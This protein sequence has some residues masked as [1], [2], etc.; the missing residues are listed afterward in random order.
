MIALRKCVKGIAAVK[1]PTASSDRD[2]FRNQ[3]FMT[4]KNSQEVLRKISRLQQRVKRQFHPIVIHRLLINLF[5]LMN[6][7]SH[8]WRHQIAGRSGRQIFRLPRSFHRN[9]Q[10]LNVEAQDLLV[11]A[12]SAPRC[13]TI[14]LH[15]PRL[16]RAAWER[17]LV[18]VVLVL[19]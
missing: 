9:A 18:T 16:A 6:R 17:I 11:Q 7:S 2:R 13:L 15:P 19:V 10:R 1:K 4:D 5:V 8:L 12:V 14:T 3:K